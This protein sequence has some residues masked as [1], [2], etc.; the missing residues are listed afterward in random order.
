MAKT[1]NIDATNYMLRHQK[2]TVISFQSKKHVHLFPVFNQSMAARVLRLQ[3]NY[4]HAIV[5]AKF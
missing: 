2:M 3:M 4:N 1:V 5:V